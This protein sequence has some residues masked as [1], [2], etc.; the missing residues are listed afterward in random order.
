[1][2]HIN[3]RNPAYDS[4]HL[5]SWLAP[6]LLLVPTT[7]CLAGDD[8]GPLVRSL[9]LVQRYGTA[10]SVQPQNDQKLK[11]K[12][13]K[14][15]G[16]EG[17]L[18]AAGVQG[19]M[20]PSTFAKLAGDDARLDPAEVKK[21]VEADVPEARKRLNPKVIAHADL[22]TTS[23]DMIDEAHRDAGE[24]LV[25]WIVKNYKPGQPLHVT[26]VCTGNSRRSILG[27]TMGNIAAAYYGMPEI[28]FHSG[29]TAPTAFNPRTVA[30][31]K[32]IGVEV[33][34]TG[35]EAPRGEPKTAN[36]VYTVR[37][38]V[39]PGGDRVLQDLLRRRQPPAGLRRPHGLRRGGC[40]LSRSSREPPPASRC[41]TWTRRSTTTAFTSR[42][43]T[44]SGGT[45]SAG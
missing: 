41:P 10:E 14:A 18:T 24:K 21:L 13:S 31:L 8:V 36:P 32:E 4:A 38:G 27:A 6:T 33:E 25:D 20:D 28:R 39:G 40:R 42:T 1:M 43:S 34:P 2:I 22:L 44:P 7:H 12:L 3:K 29:G 17:I 23:F 5:I 26:V 37:W 45:T 16:K 19:L 35:S 30:A 9:W 11:G 15:L